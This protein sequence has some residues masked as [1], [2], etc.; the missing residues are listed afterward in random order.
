M[1]ALLHSHAFGD[2]ALIGVVMAVGL[3]PLWLIVGVYHHKQQ[4]K[5]DLEAWNVENTKMLHDLAETV[6]HA[7]EGQ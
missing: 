6:R 7:Q 4:L 1:T 3:L 2:A 5:R